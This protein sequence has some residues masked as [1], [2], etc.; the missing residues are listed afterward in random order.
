MEFLPG[1]TMNWQWLCLGFLLPATVSGRA[2]GTA[3]KETAVVSPLGEGGTQ[4]HEGIGV[5]RHSPIQ[6][7]LLTFNLPF[8]SFPFL[9][10]LHDLLLPVSHSLPLFHLSSFSKMPLPWSFHVCPL[11]SL[12]VC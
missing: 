1:W 8:L 4:A 2:L 6:A 7:S 11:L 5:L 10:L 3:R 12:W 9:P